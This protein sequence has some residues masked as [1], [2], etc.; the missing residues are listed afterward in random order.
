MKPRTTAS[1]TAS[2]SIT[3]RPT[4]DSRVR[5]VGIWRRAAITALLAGVVVLLVPAQPVAAKPDGLRA[6][7]GAVTPKRAVPY[8]LDPQRIIFRFKARNATPIEVRVVR[9][10]GGRTVRRFVTGPLRPGLWHRLFWNGLN[11]KR[12]LVASGRYR[13]KAGPAG[14][15][16]RTIARTKLF[17]HRFPVDGPHGIR[18]YIGEFGAPRTG[19][20]IHEGFDVTAACGTPLVA[21]RSGTVL[22]T[23][24][25]PELK[26]Y[27]VVLKGRAERR[28][29]LYAHL[30]RAAP[31]KEGDLVKA[32]RRIGTVGQTGN[33]AGTPCH[34]HF[35]VR[36]RGRL[37]D[38]EPLLYSWL[39]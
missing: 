36:S 32:G 6:L 26:G 21:V 34:L 25:D 15:R 33:A 30:I 16:L 17:G 24:F 12:R 20:R 4:A 11:Q 18:G 8:S 31:V 23:A 2:S 1:S 38:P 14:A 37:L 7:E 39:G 22:K 9:V 13:V 5:R 27:Y 10:A 28:T 19:G 29:Y 35:E 3:E